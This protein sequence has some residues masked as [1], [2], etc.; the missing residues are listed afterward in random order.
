MRVYR[1]AM[2]NALIL[3]WLPELDDV[4][5]SLKQRLIGYVEAELGGVDTSVIHP[6]A[7]RI[8]QV[9]EPKSAK[10]FG[11]KLLHALSFEKNGAEE[12]GWSH[13]DGKSLKHRGD[14]L[15]AARKRLCPGIRNERY[16]VSDELNLEDLKAAAAYARHQELA[17]ERLVARTM[18]AQW[19]VN[20]TYI[21][22]ACEVIKGITATQ[23]G[24]ISDLNAYRRT[25]QEQEK[26]KLAYLDQQW[27]ET[28]VR[29]VEKRLGAGS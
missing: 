5:E 12:I 9:R 2:E 24:Q 10:V 28:L 1:R 18:D 15:V 3:D 26:L 11:E 7:E 21:E 14:E 19:G 25:L 17:L 6:M 27:K 16:V 13:A 20:N 22:N 29:N 23:N 8:V 4:D